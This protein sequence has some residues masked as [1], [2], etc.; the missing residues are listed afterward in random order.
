MNVILDFFNSV[1]DIMY[2]PVLII[3]LAVAGL[4]FTCRTREAV[5]TIRA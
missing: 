2:Y 3:V 5:E 1:D 4:F